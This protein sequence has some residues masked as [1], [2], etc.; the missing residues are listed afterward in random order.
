MVK[1]LFLAIF[2]FVVFAAFTGVPVM[3]HSCTMGNSASVSVCDICKEAPQKKLPKCCEEELDEVTPYKI[4]ADKSCCSNTLASAPLKIDSEQSFQQLIKKIEV[5][6]ELVFAPITES[7]TFGGF[8]LLNH[9]VD[10]PPPLSQ[11]SFRILFS[12]LLV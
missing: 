10:R 6:P 1:K 4:S 12:S 11:P 3:I 2:T 8:A 7:T 5:L 9:T